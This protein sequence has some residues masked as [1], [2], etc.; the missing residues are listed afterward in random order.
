MST[1]FI[2]QNKIE[3][4]TVDSTNNFAA[5]LIKETNVL[6]GTVIMAEHQT[7]GKGQS[8]NS[9][10]SQPKLNL[11]C[12]YILRPTFLKIED[13]FYL[14]M[15]ISLAVTRTL[16]ELGIKSVIK[17][18]NDILVE[19]KKIA[20]ILIE[21]SVQK[22]R[23]SHSIIG[24]G[25]NVNQTDFMSEVNATSI[26]TLLKS[27]MDPIAIQLSLNE[28]LEK[29]YLQLKSGNTSGLKKQY[30]SMLFQY[31][32]E[33]WYEVVP[34]GEQFKGVITDIQPTGAIII[35]SEGIEKTFYFKQVKFI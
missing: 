14:S 28:Q 5:N 3:L 17:W 35:F 29:Y 24:I 22:N 1:L 2:G 19:S 33:H 27:N 34:S 15:V 10:F 8:G 13:Q 20:G 11:T 32:Q 7:N 18:P 30:M 16:S 25:F 23:F 9:W 26:K 31:K 6:D 21:N 12:S 4:L